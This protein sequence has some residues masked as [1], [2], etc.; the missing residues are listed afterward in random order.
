[1]ATSLGG[2]DRQA[3]F[4]RLMGCKGKEAVPLTQ[5][6]RKDEASLQVGGQSSYLPSIVGP[7]GKRKGLVVACGSYVGWEPTNL[8]AGPCTDG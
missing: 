4:L 5:E 8:L 6:Q 3:K 7:G 2:G 1:M